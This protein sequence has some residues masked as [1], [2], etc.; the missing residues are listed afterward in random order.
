[1]HGGY[2]SFIANATGWVSPMM[3][4]NARL[5]AAL[6]PWIGMQDG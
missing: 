2:E 3:C 1:M 6:R 5:N 4:G